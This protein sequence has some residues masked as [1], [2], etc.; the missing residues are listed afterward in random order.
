MDIRHLSP[1]DNALQEEYERE[2]IRML[3]GSDDLQRKKEILLH[4][5]PEMFTNYNYRTIFKAAIELQAEKKEINAA[6]FIERGKKEAIKQL[7]IDL[8]KEYITSAN[9][10][11]YAEKVCENYINKLLYDCK[12]LEGYKVIEVLKNKYSF[13]DETTML[14]E[15]AENIMLEYYNRWGTSVQTYYPSIDSKIG[16][17]QGGDLIILAGATGM[18]KTC[19][20]LN[21][22]QN[23]AVNGKK[24]L[25]ISLE[26]SLAQL[27]NRI[28]S[29]NTEISSSKV[30][31]FSMSDDEMLKYYNYALSEEFRKLNVHVCTEY[32]ITV[33]KIKQLVEKIEPD[34][35][36][37][38]YLGLITSEIRGNSYE[39]VSQVSRD[40]KLAALSTNT[41]FIVLHQLSRIGAERK[42]KR[43]LLSDLRDSGKIEQD[44]DFICFVFREAYYESQAPKNQLEFI[45]S[46]SRHGSGKAKCLL[47]YEEETQK[48]SEF[49]YFV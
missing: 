5:C 40:L 45:I 6:N 12:T 10:R 21:L 30:R 17:F 37:I 31:S 44:A 13:D 16:S 23:M 19:M 38:D 36:F 48:I 29:A 49:R 7:I 41:P 26:M 39:R 24:I 25:L 47:K 8:G 11:F 3:I 1:I 22:V 32:N 15:N 2:L 4:C 46:K 33:E 34:I 43:P 42:E 35:V 14:Y 9:Y 18:G 20:M 27:Q 28:I